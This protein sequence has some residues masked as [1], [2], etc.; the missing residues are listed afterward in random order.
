MK[1]SA[2]VL[3]L[4]FFFGL[5]ASWGIGATLI[6]GEYPEKALKIVIP[7]PSGTGPDV[8]NRILAE[9]V[10]PELG[11]PVAVI[12]VVGGSGSKGMAFVKNSPADG[13]TLI[14]NWVAPHTVVPIFNP[15][16]GY[17]ANEDFIPIAGMNFLPFTLVVKIDHEANN[18]QEFV[19]WAKKQP[20]QLKFGACAALS[21]PRMVME[22]FVLNSGINAKGIPYPGCMPENVTSVLDGSTDFTIGV[23]QAIKVFKGRIKTLAIFADKRHPL[24]PEVPTASEQGHRVG[25]GQV[26]HGWAGLSVRSDVSPEIVEKLRTV[27]GKAI[28]SEEFKQRAAKINFPIEYMPPDEFYRLWVESEKILRTPVERILREKKS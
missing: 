8:V 26:G 24:A 12:N 10:R 1:K 5:L 27:F 22:E 18:L 14:N 28:R 21:V 17:S 9:M 23:L 19:A 3:T 25:W 6:A 20:R 13:Y 4:F 16:V 11:Q 15:K 2:V 7:W